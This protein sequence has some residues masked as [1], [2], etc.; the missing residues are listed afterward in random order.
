MCTIRPGDRYFSERHMPLITQHPDEQVRSAIK[1]L[2]DV[3]VLKK[4]PPKK[5]NY[6]HMDVL[7]RFNCEYY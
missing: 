2:S 5:D 6:M 4:D 7:T 1:A 3:I